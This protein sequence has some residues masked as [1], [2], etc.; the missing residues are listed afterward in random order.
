MTQ[1]DACGMLGK[2]DLED[3]LRIID[4]PGDPSFGN[5]NFFDNPINF[6]VG[7]AKILHEANRQYEL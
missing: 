2:A 4:S 3:L 7:E 6:F 5:P 1:D